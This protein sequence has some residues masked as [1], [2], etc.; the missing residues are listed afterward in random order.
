MLVAALLGG[1]GRPVDGRGRARDDGPGKVGDDD[2][3]WSQVRDVALLEE[4][5]LAG[6]GEDRRNVARQ[7]ALALGE[8]HDQRHVLAGADESL[9]LG[10]VHDRDRVGPVDEPQ[11][12]PDRVG[13]VAVVGLL[14]EVGERLGVGLRGQPMAARLEAVPELAE[15][16][17]DPVVD[18][19][20][21]TGAVLV[22]MRV[23]VVR[24]AV[25]RPARVGQADGGVGRAIGDRCA[26]IRELAGL[27]LDEQGA[28][29]IDE[30]DPGR[31]V[32][33]VLEALQP[34]DEDRSRLPR[35]RVSDDA[36]HPSGPPVRARRR[37]PAG[38]GDSFGRAPALV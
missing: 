16:L 37:P 38:G 36:A 29:V 4:H 7:E 1:L 12:R 5:D 28:L 6:V 14:D 26:Q 23:E 10:A 24:A 32:A 22:G 3:G 2:P 15:V 20:D 19:R 27:L 34:L 13:E 8:A 35:S 30:G 17:E 9:R 11:R 21:V 18:D 33:A 25:G 31:V